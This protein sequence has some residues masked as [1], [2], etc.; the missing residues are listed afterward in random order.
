MANARTAAAVIARGF[1]FYQNDGSGFR[2][3]SLSREDAIRLGDA[4]AAYVV[5]R[6]HLFT[7]Q[8]LGAAR[9]HLSLPLTGKPLYDES[10]SLSGFADAFLDEARVTLPNVGNKLLLAAVIVA[11]VYFGV[12]AWKS[13][14][15]A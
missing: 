14:P 15:A 6:P 4:V 8:A 13:T 1:G 11:A 5:E 9:Y 3:G 12:K 10:L 2:M 7:A